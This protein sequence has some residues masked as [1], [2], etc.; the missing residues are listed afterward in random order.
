MHYEGCTLLSVATE[1]TNVYPPLEKLRATLQ[2]QL[3]SEELYVT[4]MACLRRFNNVEKPRAHHTGFACSQAAAHF[5]YY[6]RCVAHHKN[7]RTYVFFRAASVP[8]NSRCTFACDGGSVR[9]LLLWSFYNSLE[10]QYAIALRRRPGC[11]SSRECC[12][13]E[14]GE[15]RA[16]CQPV[17]E[18]QL[19]EVENELC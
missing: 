5:H 12:R 14:E 3:F 10:Q 8:C 16:T 13:E 18:V 11:R 4:C 1:S 2:R 7:N 19:P 6:Y 15:E 17:R 9:E